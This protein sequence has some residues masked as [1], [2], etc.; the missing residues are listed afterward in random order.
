MNI[1]LSTYNFYPSHRG[2]TEVYTKAFAYFL[3]SRGHKVLVI[4]ADDSK[5]PDPV[6][7]IFNSDEIRAISYSYERIEVIGIYQKRQS[8]DDIYLNKKEVW[9]DDFKKILLLTGWNKTDV[10]I[11]NGFNTVSGISLIEAVLYFNSTAKISVI[12]HTPFICPKADMIYSRKYKRCDVIMS[13]EIC[14]A[15]ITKE[16]TN[17]PFLFSYAFQLFQKYIPVGKL[18]KITGFRLQE[19]LSK[20]FNAFAMLNKSVS[21][22]IVFSFEMKNFLSNQSFITSSKIGVIRHGID[23]TIF[24]NNATLKQNERITFLYSGR[25]EEIKGIKV[26]CDAW[27][28]LEDLPD[29]RQLYLAGNWNATELGK[30]IVDQLSERKDVIIKGSL[31]QEELVDLYRKTHCVIIP[32][33][34]VETGPMVYHEAIACGCDIITSDVGGQLELCMVYKDKSFVFENKNKKSLTKII[35]QYTPTTT[36]SA[37]FPMSFSEHFDY[38]SKELCL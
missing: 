30:I 24:F 2:G 18:I 16:K 27:L 14:G 29:I 31:P 23:K 5:K 8:P 38:L 28:D 32:S 33:T 12:V 17:L 19:L 21:K 7:V 9:T 4:A 25:F 11:L 3:I 6:Q 10:L 26:L 34:G 36:T 35:K 13:P 15:C 37:N 22:W 20:K 1:V